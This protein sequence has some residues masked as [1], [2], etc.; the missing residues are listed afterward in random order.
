[1]AEDRINDKKFDKKHELHFQKLEN[2]YGN[3]IKAYAL[4]FEH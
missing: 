3:W 2:F 1:M 4:I